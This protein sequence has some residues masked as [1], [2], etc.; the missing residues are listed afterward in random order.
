LTAGTAVVDA[1]A[2][3]RITL[4]CYSNPEKTTITNTG[5]TT[6]RVTKVGSTYQPYSY[7]PFG[8]NKTLAPGQAV[9]YLTG[10]AA[11]GANKLTGTYIYND[12]GRD[13]ARITTTIGTITKHC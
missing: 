10:N 12:N 11:S 2:S 1:A 9:T 7:E 6:I 8:L 4:R 3:V 13:S 5:T